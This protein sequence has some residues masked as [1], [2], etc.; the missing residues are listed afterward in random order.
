MRRPALLV[1][2]Q[3]GAPRGGKQLGAWLAGVIAA[4]S[5]LTHPPSKFAKLL[6]R[7]RQARRASLHLLNALLAPTPFTAPHPTRFPNLP[8]ATHQ[9]LPAS[10]VQHLGRLKHEGGG[11]KEEPVAGE[12][13]VPD[14]RHRLGDHH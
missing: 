11:H 2:A 7:G 8:R 14:P 10:P 6:R 12:E 5:S 13:A 4:G 9:Q 3:M 1:P